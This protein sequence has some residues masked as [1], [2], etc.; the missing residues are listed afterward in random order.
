MHIIE[1]TDLAEDIVLEIKDVPEAIESCE[2]STDSN[3]V[4]DDNDVLRLAEIKGLR[5]QIIGRRSRVRERENIAFSV[6]I[7]IDKT[8]P[9]GNNR[10]IRSR[11]HIGQGPKP[12][13]RLVQHGH[14][15]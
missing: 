9:S 6:I 10:T 2:S 5:V 1:L 8:R 11:L 3:K 4:S 7:S 14:T 15:Q 12:C 13:V